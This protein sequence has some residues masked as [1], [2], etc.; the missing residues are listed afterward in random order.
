MLPFKLF[1]LMPP[2]ASLRNLSASCLKGWFCTSYSHDIL[3]FLSPGEERPLSGMKN[4]GSNCSPDTSGHELSTG[5][6]S[7]CPP[8]CSVRQAWGEMTRKR[9]CEIQRLWFICFSGLCLGREVIVL[10][11]VSRQTAQLCVALT[12]FLNLSVPWFFI[13]KIATIFICSSLCYGEF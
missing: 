8:P 1:F 11:P 5:L 12:K 2:S 9:F 4:P 6:L 13:Y 3:P 10:R 7:P